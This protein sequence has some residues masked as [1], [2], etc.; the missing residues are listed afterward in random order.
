MQALAFVTA[1]AGAPILCLALP[2]PCSFHASSVRAHV[3]LHNRYL[4][5]Q[6]LVLPGCPLL[7]GRQSHL[8][9]QI[10]TNLFPLPDLVGGW[11]GSPV[12]SLVE[13]IKERKKRRG[14]PLTP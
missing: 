4:G 8:Q 12:D 1:T 14:Q 9:K 5:L 11:L 10:P 13:C 6:E 7:K 2:H 3:Q